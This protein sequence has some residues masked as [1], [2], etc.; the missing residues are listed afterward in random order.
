MDHNAQGRS[1]KILVV[2]IGA[3]LPCADAAPAAPALLTD[4]KYGVHSNNLELVYVD[5]ISIR[6]SA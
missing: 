1:R 5:N 4:V 6:L 3:M 2:T